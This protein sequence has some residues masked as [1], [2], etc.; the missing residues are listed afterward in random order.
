VLNDIKARGYL[1]MKSSGN[2]V[3]LIIIGV[4][5]MIILGIWS[6]YLGAVA[7]I[8][9]GV[10]LMVLVFFAVIMGH[11]TEKGVEIKE[12][13]LGLKL[14]LETAEKD[15]I[16]FHNAPAKNPKR[17]EKLLPYAMVFG[18]EKEWAEQFEDIYKV[19][20]DWYDGVGGQSFNSIILADSLHSFSETTSATAFSAPSSAGAGGS[21]FS[22]GGSGGGFGGG[23]GG[24]W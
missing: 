18:V 3:A 23:G 21:G 8:A 9:G 12:K 15:R 24:S 5:Q 20:P 6:V 14:Y 22:G 17:F 2:G 10:S 7:I 4:V 1:P 19:Q 11:R 16:K 13:L